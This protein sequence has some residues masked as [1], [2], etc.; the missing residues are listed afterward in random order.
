MGVNIMKQQCIN[1]SIL[2]YY[3]TLSSTASNHSL[4]YVI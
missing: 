4:F 3:G 1:T 2:K